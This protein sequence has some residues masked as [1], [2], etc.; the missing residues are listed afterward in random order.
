MAELD[1]ANLPSDIDAVLVD[2]NSLNDTKIPDTISL[3][4][5]N[6]EAD[7]AFTTQMADSVPADGTISTREQA[8][9]AILHMLTEFAIS[10]TTMTVRK[11]DGSTTLMTFTLDDGTNPTSLTR[12]T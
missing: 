3:A 6:A 9:Y 4:N 5:I 11:V 12:A 8:I 7:T 1:A 10:G 2:T